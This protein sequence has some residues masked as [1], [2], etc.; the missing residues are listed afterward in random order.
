MVANRYQIVPAQLLPMTTLDLA[1]PFLPNTF[2]IYVSEYVLFLYAFLIFR[3]Y[4]NWN[5]FVYAG[6]GMHIFCISIF[7]IWPTTYPRDLFP[8]P[9]ETNALTAQVFTY[10]RANLDMPTNC[11]PSLHVCTVFL[12]AFNFLHEQRSKFKWL[13]VWASSV[14]VTTLT[15]KQHYIA[16]VISG[17]AVAILMYCIFY[18]WMPYRKVSDEA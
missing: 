3:D 5:K 13:M 8:I 9:A 16:D 7:F 11:A 6:V 2:W 15:T 4:D 1:I 14:A 12:I 10:F 18:K 17:L